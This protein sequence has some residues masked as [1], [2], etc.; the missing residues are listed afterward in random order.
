MQFPYDTF[1][2][3]GTLS[4]YT[5]SQIMLNKEAAVQIFRAS[6]TT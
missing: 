6:T 4:G 2:N 3:Q 5:L 1:N